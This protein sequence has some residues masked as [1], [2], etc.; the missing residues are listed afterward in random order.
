MP[1]SAAAVR[2]SVGLLKMLLVVATD[3]GCHIGKA[4]IADFHCITV[5]DLGKVSILDGSVD[6]SEVLRRDIRFYVTVHL[7]L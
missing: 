5:E 1:L 6:E 3:D 7:H 4:A 2:Y